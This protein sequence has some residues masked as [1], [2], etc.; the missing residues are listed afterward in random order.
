M[1]TLHKWRTSLN[2]VPATKVARHFQAIQKVPVTIN[3]NHFPSERGCI[4]R[5]SLRILRTNYP[6]AIASLQLVRSL[7][8][9]L[10]PNKGQSNGVLNYVSTKAQNGVLITDGSG[11]RVIRPI[12]VD[13]WARRRPVS[14]WRSSELSRE[15]GH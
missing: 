6:N 15:E 1:K 8:T 14:L 10:H 2:T 11:S 9:R 5:H 12:T 7:T 3:P 13:I 4:A